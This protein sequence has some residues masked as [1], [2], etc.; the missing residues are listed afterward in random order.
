MYFFKDWQA[1]AKVRCS[2]CSCDIIVMVEEWSTVELGFDCFL[3]CFYVWRTDLHQQHAY[4]PGFK[5][6]DHRITKHKIKLLFHPVTLI[7]EKYPLAKLT[8]HFI[9]TVRHLLVEMCMS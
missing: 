7:L 3:K 8:E 4:L 5:L 2:H 1:N 6:Y 9:H